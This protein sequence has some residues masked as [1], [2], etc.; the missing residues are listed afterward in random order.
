M[1]KREIRVAIAMIALLLI[2][3][4]TFGAV[5]QVEDARTVAKNLYYER[6]QAFRSVPFSQI[7]IME[8][9]QISMAS[10]LLYYVFNIGNDEGFVIISAEDLV[11]PVLAYS[12]HGKFRPDDH[13]PSFLMQMK[14]YEDQILD[15]RYEKALPVSEIDEVWTKYRKANFTPAKDIQTVGPICKTTWDQGGYYNDSCPGNSVTGCVATMMAQVMKAFN[16]PPKGKGSYSYVH[17]Y[18]GVQAANFGN[19]SYNWSGMPN[20]VSAPNAPVAQLMY[21][22]GV[23]VDMGYSPSG[24]GASMHRAKDAFYMYFQYSP[25]IRVAQKSAY[26][27]IYWKILVRAQHMNGRP[28]MYSGPGHAFI[29]D[30]FQYPDHFHFNWGWGGSYDGYYYLT[31]L[32]PGNSNYT[33]GQ[34]AIFE[35]YPDTTKKSDGF[36]DGRMFLDGDAEMLLSPNPVA[37]G[38]T[39]LS[40]INSFS[41]TVY[42]TVRNLSGQIVARF[43]VVKHDEWSRTDLDLSHLNAGFYLLSA[44]FGSRTLNQRLVV[45]RQ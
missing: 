41:G 43:S 17:T 20:V 15:A 22:C 16:W 29:C 30:G 4:K 13:H 7:K 31:S 25:F 32:R 9:F 45:A 42:I 28:V 1:I 5:V 3:T 10:E 26:T 2:T 44:E 11:H 27:D 24:S 8:E 35:A 34:D 23:S 19:T 12:F 38:R 39:E 6:V 36:G 33:N 21:H 37:E 40:L 18:Y 14:L